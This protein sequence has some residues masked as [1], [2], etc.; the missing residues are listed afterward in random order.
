MP[1]LWLLKTF[2]F[3]KL[4]AMMTRGTGQLYKEIKK[5]KRG[6]ERKGNAEYEGG[7][8]SGDGSDTTRQASPVVTGGC[9]LYL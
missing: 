4:G 7:E 5:I 3:L 1:L 2:T 8:R 6:K 9:S